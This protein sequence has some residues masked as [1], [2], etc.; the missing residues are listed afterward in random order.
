MGRGWW[1]DRI[2]SLKD[3]LL[4]PLRFLLRRVLEVVL[5]TNILL[6][7]FQQWI[8]PSVKNSFQAFADLDLAKCTE[9]LLKLS[10]REMGETYVEEFWAREIL[11]FKSF[12]ESNILS[13]SHPRRADPQ[14]HPVAELVLPDVPL[15]P[16][17]H[18]GAPE[19]RR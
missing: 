11:L 15:L 17:H 16:Q 5:V 3:L 10:V 18:G 2:K 6:A 12:V 13:S 4:L 19:V 14:P 8:I 1:F 7:M 9:R